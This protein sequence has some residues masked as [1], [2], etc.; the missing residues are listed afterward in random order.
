MC[1]C[2]RERERERERVCVRALPPP[3]IPLLQYSNQQI[4]LYARS[5][6]LTVISGRR[7]IQTNNK[8]KSNTIPEVHHFTLEEN[9]RQ[10]SRISQED[11]NLGGKN[12]GSKRNKK[13]FILTYSRLQQAEA[14]IA[15]TV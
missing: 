12:F 15:L 2:V 14:L 7:E 9:W 13:S 6:A 11:K 10:C 1:V 8:L 4:S 5:I 3:P